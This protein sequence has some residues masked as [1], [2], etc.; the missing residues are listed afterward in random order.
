VR[1]AA[2]LRPPLA[3]IGGGIAALWL[4][5]AGCG[6]AGGG[7]GSAGHAGVRATPGAR[8]S[9]STPV[10]VPAT[11]AAIRPLDVTGAPPAP[12]A[13]AGGTAPAPVR[14]RIAA[15]GVDTTLER[16]G[17]NGD[18][19]IEVPSDPNQAGWYTNGPA[20]GEQGPAVI[21]GHLDSATGPAV[22]WRLSSL[23]AGSEVAVAREDGSTATFVVQ[24]VTSFPVDRFPTDQVYGATSDPELRLITCGGAYSVLQRRYLNNVV[25]FAVLRR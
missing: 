18:G 22:F 16:L 4:A 23:K 11:P 25:V 10:M 19:T 2:A 20:P 21:L 8:T 24:R 6:A 12:E 13:F 5:V 14:L 3:R 9:P 1:A 17:L 15:I 7:G